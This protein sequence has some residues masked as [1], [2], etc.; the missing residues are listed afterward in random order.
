[1]PLLLSLVIAT[2]STATISDAIQIEEVSPVETDFWTMRARTAISL[3]SR[4]SVDTSFD[5]AEEQVGELWLAARLELDVDLAEGFKAYAAPNFQWVGAVD[6]E[7]DDRQF[8]YLVTPEAYL[9]WASGP[10]MIRAGAIVFS[11]GPSDIIA[12]NDLFNPIDYRRSLLGFSDEAKIPVL[13]IEGG[14]TF[15]PVDLRAVIEPFFASSCFHLAVW[16][17]SA[18][19]AGVFPLRS[20]FPI[21]YFFS[22]AAIDQFG[23]EILVTERSSDRPDNATF[24]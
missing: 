11:W 13:A 16:D 23:N 18:L 14:G 9:S 6:R 8:L 2:S 24:G 21:D 1:M 7:G 17:F 22:E 19:Q 5:R 3:E 20:D 15:G 4:L 10:F 12:P